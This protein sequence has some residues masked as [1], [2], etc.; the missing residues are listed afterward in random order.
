MN[1]LNQNKLSTIRGV[2]TDIRSIP[3]QTGM[4]F[5][6]CKV[7]EHKCKLFG[8]L[9]KLILANQYD[10]EGQDIEAYGHWDVR[11]GNE[12][13]ID[14]IGKQPIHSTPKPVSDNRPHKSA[15]E[16]M[17]NFIVIT[18][19]AGVTREQVRQIIDIANKALLTVGP[20]WFDSASAQVET[21]HPKDRVEVGDIEF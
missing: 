20:G 9:A 6:V 10:S 4:V 2:L 3:T 15:M 7:G 16:V 1:K 19:P 8:D 5:A 18:I 14:G 21:I 13:V 11:R 17:E 12:F